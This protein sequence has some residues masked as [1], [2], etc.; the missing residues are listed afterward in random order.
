MLLS[1]VAEVLLQVFVRINELEEIK[2]QF[3]DKIGK[4]L[5]LWV[6]I[7]ADLS[8]DADVNIVGTV[9]KSYIQYQSYKRTHSES[10]LNPHWILV[11]PVNAIACTFHTVHYSP[12]IALR[13]Y[14]STVALCANG[15]PLELKGKSRSS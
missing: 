5:A 6:C 12:R 8:E 15:L 9:T 10:T 2:G 11:L 13:R 4:V 3:L 7:L 14:L 1:K